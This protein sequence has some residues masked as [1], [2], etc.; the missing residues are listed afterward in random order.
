MI[1]NTKNIV[2]IPTDV[3]RKISGIYSSIRTD[4]TGS[5]MLVRNW[6]AGQDY[7]QQHHFG[8]KIIKMFI[9]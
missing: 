2:V 7:K 6:L 8:I 1:N 9:K 3:H 4:L 5:D